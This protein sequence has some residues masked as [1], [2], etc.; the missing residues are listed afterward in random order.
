MSELSHPVVDPAWVAWKDPDVVEFFNPT[1]LLLDRHI[2]Q[3]ADSIAL[4]IDGIHYTYAELLGHVNRGANA[5][6]ASGLRPGERVLLFG[7]DSLEYVSIWLG[8][9]RLGAVPVAVADAYRAQNLRYFIEDTGARIL[10]IDGEQ[11]A[12]FNEIAAE[13]PSS[14]SLVLIRPAEDSGDAET[15]IG[16]AGP[17]RKN[18]LNLLADSSDRFEPV[19]V[20][21]HDVA[22]MFYSGGTTGTA[23]GI[24]HLA[25]DFHIVPER[26]AA[27]W[28]TTAKDVTHATSKKFFSHGIWPGLLIPLYTGGRAV[29]TR[30]P[31]TPEHLINLIETEK[32]SGLITVPTVIKNLLSYVEANG[33]TFDF[34]SIKLAVTASEKIP[35]EIFERFHAIFGIELLDAIGNSEVTYSWLCNTPSNFKRGSLGRPTYGVTI[36]LVGRDGQTITNPNTAGEAYVHSVTAAP[37]YWRKQKQSLA[38]FNGGW[39][40]TGDELWFD[41][42]GFY[43]FSGRAN[44][45]FKVKG[46]WVSPIEVEAEIT[47][48]P[49]VYEAAVIPHESADGLTESRAF[50]VLKPGHK[51]SE[52]LTAELQA[53]IKR[54]IGGYKVPQS[55]IYPSTLPRTTLMKIDRRALRDL[56]VGQGTDHAASPPVSVEAAAKRAQALDTPSSQ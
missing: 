12:K 28:K 13:L 50:V 27:V 11:L 35:P 54:N 15:R 42:D 38:T 2:A 48:H 4:S 51:A 18:V 8:A 25:Q 17:P 46:L 1:E 34:S 36:K 41:E 19:Q 10:A 49:A 52:D 20:H 40:R 5:L 6:N 55:I 31:P 32:P 53:K 24:P 44:D 14:L 26:Q 33:R 56:K 47:S 21:K 7:I 16:Q 45:L 9:L 37:F 29:L 30:K 39:T 22:Y 43:W 23:K 3:N